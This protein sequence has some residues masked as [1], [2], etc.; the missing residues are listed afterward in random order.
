MKK[1]LK[2]AV[3]MMLLFSLI[4]SGALVTGAEADVPTAGMPFGVSA[5]AAILMD[6]ASG[7]VLYEKN[8][9]TSLRIASITKIMTAIVA[10]ELGNLDDLVTVS[11][12]AYGV[13]G[14][15]IYLRQGEKVT[16]ENLLYG[17]M[18]RSGNDAA[19]AIAEHIGGSTEG[20]VFLMN[21]KAEELGM[22]QTVFSNPHGLDTHEEHYASAYDMALLTAYAMK[23]DT[24]ATIVGTRKKNVAFEGEDWQRTWYNKNRLLTMYPY[25]NGV[26]TGFTKR[27]RRTL[28]S[29]A[30]KDGHL[31]V[32]VTLNAPDDWNDHMRM[33]EYG[34]NHYELVD[35]YTKG[36]PFRHERIER[37]DGHFYLLNDFRY[38]L[39]EQESLRQEVTIDR[40]FQAKDLEQ[41]PYP[42]GFITFF[43]G[44]QEVGRLPLAFAFDEDDSPSWWSRFISLIKWVVGGD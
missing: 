15:S 8:S 38:P 36:E 1:R 10:I 12:N 37:E 39:S 25:A 35:Y 17:L 7:R 9:Q 22:R 43:L 19:V 2:C 3:I 11:R 20:F 5:E 44:Q 32:A 41:V 31:L 24:F 4:C 28:V 6:V 26:K 27:A 14:S 34:F 16:L 33:F 23:N 18:L 29:S 21:Q 30:E 40:A 42:A 13:E